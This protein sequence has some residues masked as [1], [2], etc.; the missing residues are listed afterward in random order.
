VILALLLLVQEA[1]SKI[2]QE[3][4]VA[5]AKDKPQLH[6]QAVRKLR[7]RGG[8]VVAEEV[9]KFTAAHGHNALSISFTE[10]LGA[11]KDERITALLRELIRDKEFYWRPTAF[12]ALAALGDNASRDDFRAALSDRLWGCRAA[13]ILALE[14]LRDRESAPR[15]KELLGDDVYDVRAQAAKTLYAFGDSSGL[16]VLVEALRA[17]TV[18]FDIDYGQIARE[19]AWNFLKLVAKDDFGYKPWETAEERAPGLARAQAWIARTMPDWRDRVPEKARVRAGGVDYVFGFERRSCQ[20]G[21]FFF[22]L[23]REGNLVLGYFTLETAKLGADELKSFQAALDKVKTLDRSLPYGQGGCDFEQYYVRVG[24]RFEKL[25]I[26][27]QGRP[28]AAEPFVRQVGELLRKKF[29]ERVLEEFRQSS[30][31]FRMSE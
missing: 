3:I 18:W 26:G 15:I 12:R 13:A 5:N 27:L 29:G 28:A 21:D 8:P 20:R 14:K 2:A 10:G 24:D 6:V 30:D 31:L 11:L 9:V 16:P 23:D 25:W 4:E 19:D 17:N 22:R 1:S 7:D